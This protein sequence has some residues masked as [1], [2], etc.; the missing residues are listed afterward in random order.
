MKQQDRVKELVEYDQNEGMCVLGI[1]DQTGRNGLKRF[2]LERQADALRRRS[3]LD[4]DIQAI[5]IQL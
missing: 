3:E 4:L 2:E 1:E 5:M